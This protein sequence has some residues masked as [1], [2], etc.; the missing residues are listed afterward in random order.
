MRL[1][2]S[3][4]GSARIAAPRYDRT[5]PPSIVHL[6]V[7]AFAR[8]HLGVY[9]DD[10]LHAGWPATIA[11]VSLRNSRT[12]TQLAPQ[13]GLYTVT[14]REPE[15]ASLRMIGSLVSMTTG[16]EAAVTAIA[17]GVQLVTLTVTEKGYEVP[18]EDLERPER[19]RSAPGVIARALDACRLAD[20]PA[21]I[22][23]P[24]DNVDRNGAV[25]RRAVTSVAE[26]LDRQLP[27]WLEAHVAFPSSVVDRMVPATSDA[28]RADVAGQLGLLDHAAVVAEAHRSWVIEDVDGLPP[29]REVGVEVVG[30]VEE[31]QRRKLWLLNGPH[32]AVAC[33]GLLVGA[34]TIADAAAH[35]A[36]ER[37]VRGF[38]DDVLEVAE[39]PAALDAHAFVADTIRRF[40]NPALGHACAQVA[41]DGSLKLPQR[42]FPVVVARC[43]RGLPTQRLATVVAT[44]LAAVAGM[45]VEGAVLPLI[46]D[47]LAAILRTATVDRMVATA[48]GDSLDGHF[49]AEVTAT[50]ERLRR[51]GAAVLEDVRS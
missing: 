10:L 51:D 33:A 23:A 45:P 1:S 19:A 48:F 30:N 6:G 21:P 40:R 3:T 11:G 13:D 9:A 44:W 2:S 31:H 15:R 5:G 39:L 35:P 37:F 7:G 43:R 28:D 34:A 27:A 25:L 12:E 4:A 47:P 36:V 20:A 32:S 17:R 42:I 8:A 41:A 38:A 26:R 50:L 24:L 16:P 46:D 14:E 49:A 29:L 18:A 22:V